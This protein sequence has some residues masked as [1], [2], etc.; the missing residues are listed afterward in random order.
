M[1]NRFLGT[2]ALL[3]A[4]WLATVA[5]LAPAQTPPATR[6]PVETSAEDKLLLI[7][8]QVTELVETV[9]AGSKTREADL[10]KTIQETI[11]PKSWASHGGRGTMDYYPMTMTLVVNQT[12]D[13]QEMIAGLLTRMVR[14]QDTQVVLEVRL[15]TVPGG[16]FERIGVDFNAKVDHQKGTQN[17]ADGYL[18]PEYADGVHQRLRPGPLPPRHDASAGM[19]RS[20]QT[21]N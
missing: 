1:F 11:A 2:S 10:I 9:G 12:P 21:H 17:C 19:H 14:G 6:C 8:Y 15:V 13:V 4:G 16:F 18:A 5:G 20:L 7:P 3:A